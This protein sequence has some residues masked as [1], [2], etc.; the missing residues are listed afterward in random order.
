MSL[1]ER[2]PVEQLDD[3]RLTNIERKLVV[4]VSEMQPPCARARRARL[5]AACAVRGRGGAAIGWKLHAPDAVAPA[6][7]V[8]QTFAIETHGD[9]AGDRA[10]R[11]DDRERAGDAR[12]CRAHERTTRHRR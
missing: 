5:R 6:P 12:R 2:I 9:R 11:C 1:R 8:A 3:E 4:R 10:R 7:E